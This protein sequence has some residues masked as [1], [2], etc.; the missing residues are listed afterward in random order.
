MR[1]IGV[2]CL[3]LYWEADHDKVDVDHTGV[4]CSIWSYSC[5]RICLITKRN[6]C[7]ERRRYVVN[8]SEL[9]IHARMHVQIQRQ[10]KFENRLAYIMYTYANLHIL[11]H[12]SCAVAMNI[13]LLSSNY[14]YLCLC[15]LFAFVLETRCPPQLSLYHPSI[16]NQ[17]LIVQ[18][19][20]S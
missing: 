18:L 4:L 9:H 5:P 8:T 14:L 7:T 1:Q 13:E 11:G 12:C 16:W 2:T 3:N 19:F 6:M 17:A 15:F 10:M 20:L